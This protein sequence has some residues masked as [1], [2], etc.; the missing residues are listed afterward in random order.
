MARFSGLESGAADLPGGINLRNVDLSVG[1][2]FGLG[3]DGA[4]TATAVK[5][6]NH[7][8]VHFK[9]CIVRPPSVGVLLCK[10]PLN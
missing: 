3:F 7:L 6:D 4:R 5:R 10:Q 8:F 2:Q 9:T 1:S